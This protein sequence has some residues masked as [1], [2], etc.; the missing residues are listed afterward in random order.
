MALFAVLF[1]WFGLLI[2]PLVRWLDQT[3][4]STPPS[5][6]LYIRT[7]A[8]YLLLGTVSAIALLFIGAVGV[9]TVLEGEGDVL[10]IPALFY[11]TLLVKPGAYLI[12]KQFRRTPKQSG[13]AQVSFNLGVIGYSALAVPIIAGL[14]VTIRSVSQIL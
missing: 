2:A 3:L 8:A 13:D 6:P 10:Y 5:L 4:P 11:Y 9:E 12:T 1:P 14:V 7:I